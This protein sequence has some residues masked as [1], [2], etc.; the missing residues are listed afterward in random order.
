VRYREGGWFTR[1]PSQIVTLRRCR[2]QHWLTIEE[3]LR[4]FPRDAFDYVWLIDPPP[5][6]PRVAPDLQPVWRDGSS[7]LY[8]VIRGGPT[9][10]PAR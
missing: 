5:Y 8:R 10:P 4:Q 3:S 2:G 7:V 1:D 6:D 9:A